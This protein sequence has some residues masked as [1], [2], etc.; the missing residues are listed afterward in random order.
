MFATHLSL[1]ITFVP[2]LLLCYSYS[3]CRFGLLYLD[4]CV[5]SSYN[6]CYTSILDL[7]V[8]LVAYQLTWSYLVNL[9]FVRVAK[10]LNNLSKIHKLWICWNE[11]CLSFCGKFVFFS[12]SELVLVTLQEKIAKKKKKKKVTLEHK[13]AM[14]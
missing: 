6:L 12:L 13:S 8:K 5:S 7:V 2:L 9:C 14:D 11:M 4:L 1:L 3:S 10:R